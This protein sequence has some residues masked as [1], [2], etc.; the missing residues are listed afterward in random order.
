LY[1]QVEKEGMMQGLDRGRATAIVERSPVP[2]TIAGGITTIE[3][4]CFLDSIGANGQVGMALY[5][6]NI[7]LEDSMVARVDFDKGN[8]LVPTVVQDIESRDVLM[9]AY[10]NEASLR[11]ALQQRR[12]I[13]W[14]RSRQELWT[15]GESSGHTQELIAVD[16]DCDGDTLLFQIRQTGEACHLDRWSCFPRISK[17][18]GLVDLDR[19]LAARKEAMPE[20]SYTAK[21]FNS[22]DLRAEKLR[23]ETEE[24]LEAKA[25]PD[26]RWEAA[27]LLYFTLVEAR[28]GGVGLQDIID[29]LRSRHGNS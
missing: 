12:G 11:A 8:G 3:D 10:S 5:T 18:W 9:T 20:G 22:A 21:L 4:V 17:R 29:E 7:T 25:F 24:L 16:L 6:G 28:A 1:T 15:K 14:S 27:D 23:E 13:Y 19:T 26:K 2:V